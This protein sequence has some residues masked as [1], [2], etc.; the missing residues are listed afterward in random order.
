MNTSK[1]MNR[2]A[3]LI[4][5]KKRLKSNRIVAVELGDTIVI[6]QE[7]ERFKEWAAPIWKE[8]RKQHLTA[9]DIKAII[10]EARLNA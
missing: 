6:K 5:L 8:A 2:E 1:T 4:Y 10:R 7:T 9:K 3:M